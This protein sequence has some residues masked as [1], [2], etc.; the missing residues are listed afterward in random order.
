[1]GK[2]AAMLG[3]AVLLSKFCFN[4]EHQAPKGELS[5]SPKQ[6]VLTLKD[7]INLK[8]TLRNK[9]SYFNEASHED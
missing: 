1:M 4:F 5:F 2:L 3:L 7:D 6:F 8:V 9:D